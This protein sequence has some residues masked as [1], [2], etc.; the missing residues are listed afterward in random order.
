MATKAASFS[1]AVDKMKSTDRVQKKWVV[2]QLQR[3]AGLKTLAGIQKSQKAILDMLLP[4]E[5]KIEVKSV[6]QYQDLLSIID[7]FQSYIYLYDLFDLVNRRRRHCRTNHRDLWVEVLG[8]R[9]G[10]M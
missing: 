8:G 5:N 1:L 7:P 3:T 6:R 4:G 10:T 2:Q 9:M